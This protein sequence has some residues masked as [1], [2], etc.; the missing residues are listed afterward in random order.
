MN[1]QVQALPRLYWRQNASL[2]LQ[3]WSDVSCQL[4]QR[5]GRCVPTWTCLAASILRAKTIRYPHTR[6]YGVT[7][8]KS[9]IQHWWLW[10]QINNFW[11]WE[12]RKLHSGRA[13][14]FAAPR[15]LVVATIQINA[16]LHSNPHVILYWQ[17]PDDKESPAGEHTV[18]VWQRDTKGTG[19]AGRRQDTLPALGT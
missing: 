12:R 5:S 6:L 2:I 15:G 8:Q 14:C 10:P 11:T 3:G 17:Q 4:A 16:L 7:R 18:T 1:V 19:S 13:F 9:V